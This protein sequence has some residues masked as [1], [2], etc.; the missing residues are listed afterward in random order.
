[1]LRIVLFVVLTLF[2]PLRAWAEPPTAADAAEF[3]RI[4][5][6]QIEAFKAD[7][8]ATAYSFAAPMIKRIFPTPQDFISMVRKGYMPVYR[9]K[10]YTFGKTEED[11]AGRPIQRVTLVG[12][13]GKTYEAVYS[14]ERQP[15]GSWQISGCAIVEVP[16]LNA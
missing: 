6:A 7:Q 5:T 13:D 10:S 8:D 16:G 2:L 12:P 14:M 9:P 11:S 4:I 15:D 3:Q 1:M